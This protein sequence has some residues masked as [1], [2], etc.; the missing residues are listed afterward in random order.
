[1]VQRARV[2][3]DDEAFAA[4]DEPLDAL[5]REVVIDHGEALDGAAC[6]SPVTT[7][8]VRPEEVHQVAE[9]CAAGYLVLGDAWYPGWEVTVDGATADPVRAWGFLR[10][11]RIG[12]G[13]H[14][15]VWS[16]RPRSLMLGALWTVLTATFVLGV[17]LNAVLRRR[18]AARLVA[19]G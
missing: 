11:V 12:A 9:A 5:A 19:Q 17:L 3:T 2:G 7:T 14:E 15:V 13:R 18:K 1:V 8:E 6:A 10:A 4:L 16:Y